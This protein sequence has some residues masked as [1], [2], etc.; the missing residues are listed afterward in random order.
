[1][2]T[3][4]GAGLWCWVLAWFG[5][6][7]IGEHPEML[8]SPEHMIH[9]VK[10]ELIWFV[11]GVLVLAALYIMVMFWKARARKRAAAAGPAAD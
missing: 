10:D 4:I 7:V 1:V 11:A 8:D 6:R 5:Q 9:A 3:T 2:V